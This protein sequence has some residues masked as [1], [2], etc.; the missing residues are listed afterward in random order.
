M[1]QQ[2]V[3]ARGEIRSKSKRKQRWAVQM[4]C[5]HG[6][7]NC[8]SKT[9]PTLTLFSDPPASLGDQVLEATLVML[10]AG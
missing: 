4:L 2:E 6:V 3:P 10:L 7:H 5:T 1:S 9:H 8:E